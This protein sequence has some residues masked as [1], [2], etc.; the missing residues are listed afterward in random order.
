VS[1]SVSPSCYRLAVQTSNGNYSCQANI[2]GTCS[3]SQGSGSYSSD[4]DIFVIVSK[5][6]AAATRDAPTYLVT[7][8]L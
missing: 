3:V 7:G 2:G 8:H 5:T 6:C 4:S 1:G